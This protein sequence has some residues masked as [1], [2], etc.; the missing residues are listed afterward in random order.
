MGIEQPQPHAAVEQP[1]AVRGAT[2]GR[3]ELVSWFAQAYGAVAAYMGL[4]GLTPTG[5]PFARYHLRPDRRFDVEAG[6][7]VA[8]KIA[9]DGSTQPSALPGGELAVVWHA[10]PYDQVG[11]AYAAL[12]DWIRSEGGT[13]EGDPWEIYHDPP[14]GDPSQW[15][16]EVIQPYLP[17]GVER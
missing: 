10:G 13:A 1:T 3:E 9:G 16:T 4:H 5:R 8:A 11:E 7:P 2:L 12:A 15:R 6:F 14:A 17:A